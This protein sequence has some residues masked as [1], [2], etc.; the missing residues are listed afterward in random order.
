MGGGGLLPANRTTVTVITNAAGDIQSCR[1]STSGQRLPG[2]CTESELAL[3]PPLPGWV[4]TLAPIYNP[5][6]LLDGDVGEH[7][8]SGGRQV[9]ICY[10]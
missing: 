2:E 6:P 9:L 3:L 8:A 4:L 10:G 1:V 5:Y 7:A